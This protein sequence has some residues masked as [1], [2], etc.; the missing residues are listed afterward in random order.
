[1]RVTISPQFTEVKLQ[2]AHPCFGLGSA[3]QI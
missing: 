2:K 3:F 1:V